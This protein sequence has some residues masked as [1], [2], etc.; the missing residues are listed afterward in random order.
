M[1]RWSAP[2]RYIR[3]FMAGGDDQRAFG[4]KDRRGQRII[5]D[6][7]GDLADAVGRSR[8]DKRAVQSVGHGDVSQPS[9][10]ALGELIGQDRVPAE[11][12]ARERRQEAGR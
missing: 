8:R 1:F 11:H 2:L 10:A 6:S 5:G 12:L 7:R 4:G 3:S 9:P